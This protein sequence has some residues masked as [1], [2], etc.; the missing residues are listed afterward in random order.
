MARPAS[1]ADVSTAGGQP[2][3]AINPVPASVPIAESGRVRE[4]AKAVLR[5]MPIGRVLCSSAPAGA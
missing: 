3:D 2:D 5:A 4:R 1:A